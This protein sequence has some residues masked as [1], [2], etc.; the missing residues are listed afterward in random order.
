MLG[1]AVAGAI[2]MAVGAQLHVPHGGIFVL[3]MP[4]A[5]SGLF[6]YTIAIV[7]GTVVT[8]AALFLLKKPLANANT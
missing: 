2:S 3:P 5:V 4:N 1:S 7:V 6:G 8:A